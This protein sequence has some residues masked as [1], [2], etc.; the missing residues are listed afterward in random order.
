MNPATSALRTDTGEPRVFNRHHT[1]VDSTL[2]RGLE[3]LETI[4]YTGK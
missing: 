2:R 1:A 4:G 3:L